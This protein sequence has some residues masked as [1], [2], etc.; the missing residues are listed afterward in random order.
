MSIRV[1]LNCPVQPDQYNTLLP[2]LKANL[3]NV[4]GFAGCRRV[5]ILFDRNNDEMLL[6]E[7]WQDVSSHQAY[8][9][10]IEDNGVLGQLSGFLS[11][12]PRI[13]YFDLLDI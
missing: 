8:L 3:P 7:E 2:F 6:D 13:K 11:G 1:T 4:R 12:P 9:K 5:S 10:F